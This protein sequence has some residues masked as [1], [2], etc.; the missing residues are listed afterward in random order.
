MNH[1]IEVGAPIY[2]TDREEGLL[3][4][5]AQ[6]M[7]RAAIERDTGWRKTYVTHYVAAGKI[8]QSA[9]E[10]SHEDVPPGPCL[11]CGGEHDTH[12]HTYLEAMGRL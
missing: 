11:L 9:V 10:R 7:N 12:E 3:R 6:Q 5:H 8:I 2:F 1:I 4:H